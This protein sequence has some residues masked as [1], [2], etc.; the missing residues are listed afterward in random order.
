MS[1]ALQFVA[2]RVGTQQFAIEIHSISEVISN[3]PI[4]PI[5]GAPKFV[6]GMVDLRGQLI[7]V[8][9]LR[10]RFGIPQTNTM[11]TRILILR[12]NQQKLGLI[13]DSAEQVYTIPEENIKPPPEGADF[14]LAVAKH[15]NE[16]FIILDL[17]RLLSNNEQLNLEKIV[18]RW[19]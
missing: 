2:F 10:T 7:P 11:Q 6:E 16:L 12:S 8:I 18:N 5:P 13:V 19:L 9:D 15:E 4:T 14:V 3:C 1:E 17:E